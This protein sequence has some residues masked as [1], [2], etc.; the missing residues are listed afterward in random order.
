MGN[1][2]KR[3][4]EII[5]T[6]NNTQADILRALQ[7]QNDKANEKLSRSFTKL[8]KQY[9][10][11]ILVASSQGEITA[12]EL[13]EQATEFFKC[14]NQLSANVMLNCILETKK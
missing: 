3:P 13:N 8:P 10:N 12:M 1:H 6:S 9:Q 14:S 7:V 11:M 2:L 4:L 5:A